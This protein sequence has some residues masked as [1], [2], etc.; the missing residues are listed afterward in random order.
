MKKLVLNEN[1]I[2]YVSTN[3]NDE[4]VLE[5][6]P[7]INGGIVVM[8]PHSGRVVALSGGFDF[9]LSNFNRVSQAKRQPGSAFKTLRIYS[10]KNIS[11]IW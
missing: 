6:I 7:N 1:D 10:R 4:Y 8:D 11:Q 9:K 2:I 5:Q 3:E